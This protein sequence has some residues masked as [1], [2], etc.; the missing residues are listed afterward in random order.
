MEAA[1]PMNGLLGCIFVSLRSVGFTNPDFWA[2]LEGNGAKSTDRGRLAMDVSHF[3]LGRSRRIIGCL[4]FEL[5]NPKTLKQWQD[6]GIKIEGF[7]GILGIFLSV[8]GA[9]TELGRS[10]LY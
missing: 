2:F 6:C 4:L 8:T 7:M 3:I 5:P 9:T 1:V 10:V